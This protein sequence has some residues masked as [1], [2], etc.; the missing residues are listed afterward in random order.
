MECHRLDAASY[1]AEGNR[2]LQAGD[3]VGAETCF[4]EAVLLAPDSAAALG[5]L[6]LAL[7]RGGAAAEAERYYRLAIA[8]DPDQALV[9]LNHGALLFRQGRDDEAEQSYRRALELAPE[10]PA[11]WSNLGVL[12]ASRKHEAEA[13]S[14]LRTALRL[15]GSYAKAR[16]NLGYLLLRQGRYAA[17]WQC[18]EARDWHAA[19]AARLDLPRWHGAPLA[20]KALLIGQEGGL[21]DTIM[22]ARYAAVLK[23]RGAGRI[24]LLCHPHLLPLFAGQPAIDASY[25]LD[26]ELPAA[27]WDYWVPAF[28]LPLHCA[29]RLA[30]IPAA[31]PY[32]HAA[33]QRVARWRPELAAPGLRVGLAWQGNP[34]FENDADRSL[35]D[36]ALLEPLGKLPQ[37]RFYSLQVG[38][39]AAAAARPPAGLPLVDLG[40]RIEDFADT[41]AIVASLDL[42]ISVDTAVVHLAG[43]LGKPT[44]VML[45]AHMADWRWM[46]ER[47]DSPWYPW[48]MR[49]FRQSDRGGWEAVVAAIAAALG[50]FEQDRPATYMTIGQ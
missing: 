50:K 29:T 9:H 24:G 23:A 4:A 49:L 10:S 15:D 45:P 19:L 30:D 34:H 46:A 38:P 26:A 44:W 48:V 11:A 13:E 14:C 32:L 41:A 22:M 27:G 16:F 12:L 25:A 35:P 39:G 5:N 47:T 20:G 33:P 43:A 40:S 28:S 7:D 31:L 6:A 17:G 18:L 2:L 36:L 3:L 21:G 8:T 1:F 37:V 42:V